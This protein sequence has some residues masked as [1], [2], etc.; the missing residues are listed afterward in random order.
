MQCIIT[1]KNHIKS[2]H[3]DDTNKMAH[4]SQIVRANE[5]L[6]LSYGGP[7]QRQASE[8]IQGIYTTAHLFVLVEFA[9]KT[10]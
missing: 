4:N 8:T 9:L 7:S 6:K 1:E 3:Y 10:H 2:K 5:N